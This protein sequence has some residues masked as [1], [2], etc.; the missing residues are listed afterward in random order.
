MEKLELACV[1]NVRANFGALFEYASQDVGFNNC[2]LLTAKF[3]KL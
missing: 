2:D 3:L 1:A